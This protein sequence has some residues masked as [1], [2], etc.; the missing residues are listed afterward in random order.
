MKTS[1][2]RSRIRFSA[3]AIA[4]LLTTAAMGACADGTT[5]TSAAESVLGARYHYGSEGPSEFD[6]SGLTWW[7]WRQAGRTIPRTSAAQYAFTRRISR[8]ELQPGD[9]VFYG[10]AGKV[11][12]VAM[13][14]G[15][16]NIIQARRTGTAVQWGRLDQYW[17]NN[18]IGYGRLP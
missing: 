8:A 10:Y 2:R 16:G 15:D 9:L 13:Y 17:V 14:A 7:A 18:R 12:H 3:L 1:H 11:S 6:C 5:A 4:V